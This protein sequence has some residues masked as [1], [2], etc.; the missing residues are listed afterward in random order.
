M[1]TQ[2][3]NFLDDFTQLLK[4]HNINS[5]EITDEDNCI[6]D[7][8]MRFFFKQSG[9]GVNEFSVGSYSCGTFHGIITELP[10]YNSEKGDPDDED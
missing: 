9:C 4:K 6:T 3:K 5:I 8:Y 10:S 1:Q 2:I 7:G